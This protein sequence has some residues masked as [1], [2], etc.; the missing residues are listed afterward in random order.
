MEIK[1][2]YLNL[3]TQQISPLT[4]YICWANKSTYQFSPL[5]SAVFP[6]ASP[7]AGASPAPSAAATVVHESAEAG[8]GRHRLSSVRP[9][10]DAA[11]LPSACGLVRRGGPCLQCCYPAPGA[12][13]PASGT[14][15][16][17][18]AAA[19]APSARGL[20][21][22]RRPLPP[23]LRPSSRHSASSQT[24]GVLQREEHRRR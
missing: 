5:S 10:T 16:S 12:R 21:S 22:T 20:V 7:R 24:R 2:W 19:A 1:K 17:P 23:A 8:S 3:L 6:A 15:P 11:A 13:P 14:W 9:C 18:D 4:A